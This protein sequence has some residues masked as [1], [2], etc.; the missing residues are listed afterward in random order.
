MQALFRNPLADPFVL[1]INAGASFGAAL[2][3]LTGVI[4]VPILGSFG[5][6]GGA[7]FGAAVSMLLVLAAARRVRD[8]GSL[9]VVGVMIGYLV[10]ALVGVMMH[11]SRAERVQSFV[12]WSFGTFSGVSWDRLA[13]IA[14]I[15]IVGIGACFPLAKPLNAMLLGENSAAS[16]GVNVRVVRFFS[17]ALV[18]ILSGTVTAFCGPVA[19][20]GLAVPHLCRTLSR[21][22]DHLKLLPLCIFGGAS[23]ALIAEIA[24]Q[25]G[26]ASVLPLNAVT[27]VIGAPFVIHAL[28]YSRRG[29]NK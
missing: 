22:G 6:V 7:W 14:P 28:V 3:V 20:I 11:F 10:S 2:A 18:A 17:I 9:L 25:L 1:G 5:I 29:V 4:S 12:V 23:L 26:G 24:T 27:S 16:L 13:I 15:I 8:S 21:C 19:F